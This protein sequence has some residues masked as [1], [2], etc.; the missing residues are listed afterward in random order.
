[1]S[2][3]FAASQFCIKVVIGGYNKVKGAISR[4]WSTDWETVRFVILLTSV[5]MYMI[6]PSLNL[7]IAWLVG[8][9]TVRGPG[10]LSGKGAP[11]F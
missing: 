1:M 4:D 7:S 9:N 10:P 11:Q 5:S 6:L 8:T 2:I 3:V